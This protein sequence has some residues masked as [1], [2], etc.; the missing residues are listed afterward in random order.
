[1]L[2]CFR[3]GPGRRPNRKLR[4]LLGI[5]LL[6]VEVRTMTT[7]SEKSPAAATATVCEVVTPRLRG[8]IRSVSEQY[9]FVSDVTELD[10]SAHPTNGDVY[11]HQ[12]DSSTDLAVGLKVEFDLVPNPKRHGQFRAVKAAKP[13]MDIMLT[14]A[15]R[16]LPTLA[17]RTQY[18][19]HT[20]QVNQ[21]DVNKAMENRP[22]ED[23]VAMATG[24]GSVEFTDQSVVD[25]FVEAYLEES[26]SG[27]RSLDVSF[28]LNKAGSKE[29]RE[30]VAAF[31]KQ[32]QSLGMEA[33]A[34]V[35]RVEYSLFCDTC[36]ILRTYKSAGL[37]VPGSRMSLHEL[38]LLL[39]SNK[40]RVWR[41][42]AGSEQVAMHLAKN[43]KDTIGFLQQNDMLQP[44]TILPTSSLPDM[45][46]AA[47]VWFVGDKAGTA[48]RKERS[49]LFSEDPDQTVNFFSRMVDHQRWADLYQ[50]FNSRTR[51][52]AQ[53]RGDTIPPHILKILAKAREFFD[54]TVIATPY[55]DIAGQEWQDITW[56]RLVDPYLFAFKAGL[57]YYFF[58][59]RWSDSGI[60]PLMPEMVAD[61]MAYLRKNE[62]NLARFTAEGERR[63]RVGDAKWYF[64][65]HSARLQETSLGMRLRCSAVRLEHAFQEGIL[66]DYIRGT[67]K[68]KGGEGVVL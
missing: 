15:M 53:Y 26:F 63:R 18:H 64:L 42:H 39:G 49:D 52:L 32:M 65:H 67:A 57:P 58:L 3:F 40:D 25:K 46:V 68:L 60:F 48:N 2:Y 62:S 19:A 12:D 35:Q 55:L 11:I 43:L 14:G 10:G 66:F 54:Y 36:D 30:R 41:K 24:H 7:V 31:G 17:A 4:I 6:S 61:T 56:P 5:P 47:P 20:K 29:E 44:G 8:T 21:A 1:M 38:R 16:H 13:L 34:D 59:G 23:V 37:L 45:F 50:I 9:G 22:L 27:L 51:P 28:D 33:Q